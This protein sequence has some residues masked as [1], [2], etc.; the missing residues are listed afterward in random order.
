MVNC[1]MNV[2]GWHSP[3]ATE[4]YKFVIVACFLICP[5]ASHQG[6]DVHV[7]WWS[8]NADICIFDFVEC[9]AR[10]TH[11]AGRSL[12]VCMCLSIVIHL[13]LSAFP[14]DCKTDCRD[15]PRLPEAKEQTINWRSSILT[16]ALSA[17]CQT[18]GRIF[19]H[20]G[21]D[22]KLSL[23]GCTCWVDS[24]WAV[25]KSENIFEDQCRFPCEPLFW[26]FFVYGS[27]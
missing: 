3:P 13:V 12:P 24:S 20:A 17:A 8:T 7:C 10:G 5:C 4:I 23:M 1:S 9:R 27:V 6:D 16:S 19:Y 11:P 18:Q 22:G 2:N 26:D 21:F 14:R 15:G 25:W